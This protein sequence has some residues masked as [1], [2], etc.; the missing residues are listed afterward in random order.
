MKK[1]GALN[2]EITAVISQLGHTDT[3]VIGDCGL[4]IPD[5]VKRI[6]LA[7]KPGLP[8]FIDTLEVVLEEM[9][10]EAAVLAEE[11]KTHNPKIEQQVREILHD[12]EVSYVSH[13]QLKR[14]S[15]RA[16]AVIRTGEATPY[17]NVVLRSGVI[18]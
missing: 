15:E 8:S 9:Q 14:L 4:P 5:G 13:E 17:A 7:L 18:F 6:D 2:S 16:K 1:I 10:V 12:A 3:I 11:I